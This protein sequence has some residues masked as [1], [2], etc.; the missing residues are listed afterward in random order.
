MALQAHLDAVK[1]SL[2][3]KIVGRS[4]GP[5][6]RDPGT[7]LVDGVRAS[8]TLSVRTSSSSVRSGYSGLRR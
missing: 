6:R 4:G 5:L 2:E 3:G 8:R 1:Q 7:D